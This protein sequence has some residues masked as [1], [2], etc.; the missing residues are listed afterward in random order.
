MSFVARRAFR[1]D[2]QR[3]DDAAAPRRSE[4][5]RGRLGSEGGD[6]AGSEGVSDILLTPRNRSENNFRTFGYQKILGSEASQTKAERTSSENPFF[7]V[8]TVGAVS[9]HVSKRHC[10][11]MSCNIS[12]IQALFPLATHQN[13]AFTSPPCLSLLAVECFSLGDAPCA[14]DIFPSFHRT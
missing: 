6:D 2:H 7:Q 9:A 10:P 14:T 8:K 12:V 1:R 13:E 3:G 11:T 4:A 5:R